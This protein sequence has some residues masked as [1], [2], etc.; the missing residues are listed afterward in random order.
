MTTA[1]GWSGRLEARVGLGRGQELLQDGGEAA[2]VGLAPVA[3]GA[4]ALL[5]D[6][7]DGGVGRGQVGDRDQLGPAEQVAGG[8]GLGRADEHPGLA[9]PLDQPGE[10]VGDAAVQV[11]D[12]RVVLGGGHQGGRGRGQGP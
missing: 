8:L 6:R 3:A 10:A 4:L 5:D 12:G 1:R 11:P 2:E 7:V 9:V